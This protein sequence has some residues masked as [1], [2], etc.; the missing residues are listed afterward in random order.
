MHTMGSIFWHSNKGYRF[1]QIVR[2]Q[3]PLIIPYT[4]KITFG[5]CHHTQNM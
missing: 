4:E 2:N 3:R 5:H 1:V